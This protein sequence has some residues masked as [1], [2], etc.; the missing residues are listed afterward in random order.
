MRTGSIW[1]SVAGPVLLGLVV[2]SCGGGGA[3]G[4]DS[5]GLPDAQTDL[6]DVAGGDLQTDETFRPDA[7]VDTVGET[8]VDVPVDD[9]IPTDI[10]V[11]IDTG[12]DSRPADVSAEAGDTPVPPACVEGEGCDDHNPCT[13][14]DKCVEETCQGT[15][16]EACDDGSDCTDDACTSGTECSHEIKPGWCL[17]DS[18]CFEEGDVDPTNAC[19]ACVTAVANDR[20]LAD[21]SLPCSDGS[22]CTNPDRC[23]SGQCKPGPVNCNDDKECTKDECVNDE[24][25]WTP[26]SGTACSDND[27]CTIN[28]TCNAGVCT[29][30]QVDC[31]DNEDCTQDSCGP[32]GVCIHTPNSN[33]C[34]D[35]NECTVGD[36]CVDG[37]CAP[38]SDKLVCN[39]FD[40]CTDDGCVPD[41]GCV[42]IPNRAPCDDSDPCTVGDTCRKDLC[43]PGLQELA[44]P[45]DNPCADS[46]CTKGVGCE[47]PP[48]SAPCDDN[49]PC[50]LN[51][52]CGGGI[53]QHGT[54]Q[55][56]CDDHN[57]CTTDS[58][59]EGTGCLNE[60]N[61]APC[62]DNN[63]CTHDDVCQ[64][65][66]VCKGALLADECDDGRQCTTDTCDPVDGCLNKVQNRPEC[67]PQIV[68]EFPPRGATLD[69][70]SVTVG[71]SRTITVSG[72]VDTGVDGWQ[73]R[74]FSINGVLVAPSPLD[75]TFTFD[76]VSNLGF[77]PIV[78][79]ATDEMG[80]KDHLV[81]SYYYS[82]KWYPI[83]WVPKGDPV[84]AASMVDQGLQM[85]LGP[86]AWDDGSRADPVNDIADIVQRYLKGM[87]FAVNPNA[88]ISQISELGCDYDIYL[89]SVEF[90]RNNIGAVIQPVEGGLHLAASLSSVVVVVPVVKTGGFLCPGNFVATVKV[91]SV[92]L[93]T[94]ML[95]SVDSA[96]NVTVT[97]TGTVVNMSDPT[98]N[99]TNLIATLLLNL[100]K[101]TLTTMLKDQLAAQVNTLGTTLADALQGLAINTDFTIG[102]F[103]S[104]APDTT[105]GMRSGLET[106]ECHPTGCLM[107]MKAA[108]VSQNA[109]TLHP[110]LGSIGRAA[111]LAAIPEPLPTY[112]AG[113]SVPPAPVPSIELGLHDDFFNQILYG[114]FNNGALTFDVP[115]SMLSGVDL[116]QYGITD[117][118]LSID[119]WLA[120]ILSACNSSEALH[121]QIGDLGIH[122]VMKLMG[123]PVDMDIF[124]SVEADAALATLDTPTGKELSVSIGAPTF[125]DVEISRLDGGLVGAEESLRNMIKTQL[126][127]Q[128]LSSLT[129][130]TLGSFPIPSIDLSGML[131]GLPPGTSISV[132]IQQVLR[133]HA[134]DIVSG[135]VK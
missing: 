71:T 111:C 84:P 47:Y 104:G 99:T 9:V 67:R 21:D 126:I 61:T 69:E 55:L 91:T 129:G 115:P 81:Q 103:V 94:T 56:D 29:G 110:V 88:P 10:P 30:A 39:D 24:C 38:G 34:D 125:L 102:A 128:L 51:D 96:G 59:V 70:T 77:N 73:V 49:D 52:T 66:G 123:T 72:R 79:D 112:P 117:L 7:G 11:Q 19:M 62:D 58:C 36:Q 107:G 90:D 48:N 127:P 95:I 105:L 43:E 134:Y 132:D 23:V 18:T 121:I 75:R 83:S 46:V 109:Q 86:K 45:N 41:K 76:I 63:V 100:M 60:Y 25:V 93:D 119:M 89:Q 26:L 31:N 135:W 113:T 131:P 12:I 42:Y 124:T 80:L 3:P 35:L 78:V 6:K 8:F 37:K 33:S 50:T 74:E 17:V 4:L 87:Q 92:T 27:Y 32:D 2:L 82:T 16:V 1:G 106:I 120:P 133:S 97:P 15:L 118:T 130:T 13:I 22:G 44:C 5:T 68:I 53:C 40:V 114:L 57:D 28:D 101:G 116:T 54:G 122:A 64:G 85:F 65:D 20:F 98:I 108:I 14:D